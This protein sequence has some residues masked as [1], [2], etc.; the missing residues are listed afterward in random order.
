MSTYPTITQH[1]YEPGAGAALA[2]LDAIVAEVGI[3][4][5]L[6]A[7]TATADERDEN[8]AIDAMILAGMVSP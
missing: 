2:D 4:Y 7:Y 3:T 8:E 6:M 1:E 5:P